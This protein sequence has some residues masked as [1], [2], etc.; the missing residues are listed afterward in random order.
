MAEP[1]VTL[2]LATA[3]REKTTS[4]GAGL[5][6]TGWPPE[7][8]SA[9]LPFR[10]LPWWFP[11][12]LLSRDVAQALGHVGPAWGKHSGDCLVRPSCRMAEG[13][14]A[15]E[16]GPPDSR[17]LP[18]PVVLSTRVLGLEEGKVQRPPGQGAPVQEQRT[19][20]SV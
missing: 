12:N 20:D 2:L 11:G 10:G 18:S 19:E 15:L 9:A 17:P 13:A 8:R 7:P 16:A 4:S 5:W 14:P 3:S 1:L 6:S